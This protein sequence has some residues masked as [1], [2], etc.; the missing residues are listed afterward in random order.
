MKKS[1]K[2]F[3]KLSSI[4]NNEFKGPMVSDDMY[5]MNINFHG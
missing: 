4:L 5:L 2:I 3:S 1:L